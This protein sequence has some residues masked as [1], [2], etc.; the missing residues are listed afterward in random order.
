MA[1]H[2]PIDYKLLQ[3]LHMYWNN[4]YYICTTQIWNNETLYGQLLHYSFI[5]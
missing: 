2:D 3:L 1:L 4:I 5:F